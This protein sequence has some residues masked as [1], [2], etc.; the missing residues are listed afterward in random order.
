MSV[1]VLRGRRNEQRGRTLLVVCWQQR[2]LARQGRKGGWGALMGSCAFLSARTRLSSW[3]HLSPSPDLA[4][5]SDQRRPDLISPILLFCVPRAHPPSLDI[6]SD[7]H[8][9]VRHGRHHLN[10][11]L[12]CGRYSLCTGPRTAHPVLQALQDGR[13]DEGTGVLIRL[14]EFG[15]GVLALR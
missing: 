1:Y 5:P 15:V 4:R 3:K 12:S 10:S 11:P 6:C 7:R 13:K 14:L 9:P 8:H 2:E